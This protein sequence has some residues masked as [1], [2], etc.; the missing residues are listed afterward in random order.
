MVEHA[1][2]AAGDGAVSLVG[3]VGGTLGLF[4]GFSLISLWEYIE[5]LVTLVHRNMKHV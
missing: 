5:I 1:I 3:D 4:L 2:C